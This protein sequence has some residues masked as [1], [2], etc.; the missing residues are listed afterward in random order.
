VGKHKKILE[1]NKKILWVWSV[2]AA[3]GK[4]RLVS[5][6]VSKS[7]LSCFYTLLVIFLH[8]VYN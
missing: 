5:V 7:L 4:I 8:S 1:R 3:G 2:A 6:R